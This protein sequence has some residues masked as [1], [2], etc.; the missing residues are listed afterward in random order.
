LDRAKAL[1]VLH[2]VLDDLNESVNIESVSFD[3]SDVSVT[4]TGFEVR[5]RCHLDRES[6]ET[7]EA[8]LKMHNLKMR[9]A[10]GVIIIYTAR[11]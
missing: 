7:V 8:I 9:E 4:S 6:K 2:E 10:N 11:V 3:E 1:A 5:L